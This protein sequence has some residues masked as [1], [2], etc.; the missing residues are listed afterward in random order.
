MTSPTAQDEPK[1]TTGQLLDDLNKSITR[2]NRLIYVL[3]STVNMQQ[4][5][6]EDKNKQLDALCHV[7]KEQNKDIALLDQGVD[8]LSTVLATRG[9]AVMRPSS[10]LEEAQK[11]WTK[12][13][14]EMDYGEESG[15]CE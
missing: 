1:P 14:L 11:N 10:V 5:L 4:A 15:V 12:S 9:R 6:I 3:R 8:S 13:Q 2:S 7:I